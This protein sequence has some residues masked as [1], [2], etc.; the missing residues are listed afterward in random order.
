MMLVTGRRLP[1]RAEGGASAPAQ[2][3][4]RTGAAVVRSGRETCNSPAA[5]RYRSIVTKL[6]ALRGREPRRAI[7]CLVVAFD[8]SRN[9]HPNSGDL[10]QSIS[11]VLA[12]CTI[13]PTQAFV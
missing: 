2:H 8:V 3:S 5:R 11:L 9:L 10:Y 1:R 13:C 4:R 7:G 6:L 12:W